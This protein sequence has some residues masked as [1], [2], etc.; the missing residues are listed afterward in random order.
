MKS[1]DFQRIDREFKNKKLFEYPLWMVPVNCKNR[2]WFLLSIDTSCLIE[3]KVEMRIYDSLGGSQTWKK[4]LEERNI[5]M[6]IHWKF[7]QT[8]QVEE[9]ELKI[10]IYDMYHQI[11]QQLNGI[12]C[13]IFTIMYA[14][15]L[16]ARHEIT[17]NQQDMGRFR[18][19]IYDEISTKKLENIIWDNEEDWELPVHFT[20]F[21]NVKTS[22]NKG[23]QNL[24]RSEETSDQGNQKKTQEQNLSDEFTS[25]ENQNKKRRK[26]EPNLYPS[27][28]PSYEG[29]KIYKFDNLGT[30][31]C[32][33][34]AVTS[35]IL[36]IQ[37]F[38][39]MLE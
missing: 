26:S 32:F 11:P 7:Q 31:L 8:F 9:S 38:Q 13:G 4:V 29:C 12:D 15:Y 6:Y 1:T 17:F 34:N 30:N 3:N 20:E 28:Y 27:Q 25:H 36:N 14:K 18:R 39:E 2:H 5:K 21:E 33:S 10:E 16:A 35:V 24:Y 22:R 23:K 37:G 19:K